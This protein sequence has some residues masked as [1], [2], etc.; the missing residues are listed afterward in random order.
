MHTLTHKKNGKLTHT[1]NRSIDQEYEKKY[2]ESKQMADEIAKN[3]SILA[4]TQAALAKK[5]EEEL[6]ILRKKHEEELALLLGNT[7]DANA[8]IAIK[9]MRERRRRMYEQGLI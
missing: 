7:T 6:E 3:A 9:S 1:Q 4:E 5:H 8:A 2:L